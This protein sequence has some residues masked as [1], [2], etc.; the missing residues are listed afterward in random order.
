MSQ[1]SWFLNFQDWRGSGGPHSMRCPTCELNKAH[2]GG[3]TLVC[4]LM[5]NEGK[6]CTHAHTHTQEPHLLCDLGHDPQ[7]LCASVSCLQVRKP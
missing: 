5:H 3:R 2:L 6:A 7:P 1:E 4:P